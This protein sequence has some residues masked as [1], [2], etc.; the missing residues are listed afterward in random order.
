MGEEAFLRVFP[1]ISVASP[2]PLTTSHEQSI[3]L[4]DNI[5]PEISKNVESFTTYAWPFGRA[6]DD[7]EPDTLLLR[8]PQCKALEVGE[9]RPTDGAAERSFTRC[10]R[11]RHRIA[12]HATALPW[13]TPRRKGLGHVVPPTDKIPPLRRHLPGPR[14]TLVRPR[15][16]C[17]DHPTSR[18]DGRSAPAFPGR[19]IPRD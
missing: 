17:A 12:H 3:R 6:S 1:S 18:A 19:A 15:H 4:G 5:A 13:P 14:W 8:S 9:L 7:S 2:D 11:R 10:R 16:L